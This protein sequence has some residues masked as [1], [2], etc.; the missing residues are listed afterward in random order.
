[1]IFFCYNFLFLSNWKIKFKIMILFYNRSCNRYLLMML[2]Y[3]LS[4]PTLCSE[5]KMKMKIKKME[6]SG[7]FPTLIVFFGVQ[8]FI[9]ANRNQTTPSKT[10]QFLIRTYRCAKLWKC[11]VSF[12]N[13]P[14][15]TEATKKKIITIN[16]YWKNK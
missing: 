12:P 16:K 3:T 7:C 1:M 4:C 9:G 5:K 11:L 10:K 8:V 13:S 6:K 14:R 2:K 15:N